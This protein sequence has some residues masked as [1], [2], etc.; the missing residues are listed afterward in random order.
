MELPIKLNLLMLTCETSD[1]LSVMM[2]F[3]LL[4]ESIILVS[5]NCS[6]LYLVIAHQ[7]NLV[8]VQHVT[9]VVIPFHVLDTANVKHMNNVITATQ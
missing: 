3:N 9:V 7:T 8:H 6:K 5:M 2:D 4:L 1:G